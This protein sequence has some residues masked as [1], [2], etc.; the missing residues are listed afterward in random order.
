[1]P[2][3]GTHRLEVADCNPGAAPHPQGTQAVPPLPRPMTVQWGAQDRS[4]QELCYTPHTTHSPPA[5]LARTGT[6]MQAPA[7]LCQ[8]RPCPLRRAHGRLPR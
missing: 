1:M 8:L 2:S 4:H 6:P 7:Q 5:P 3:C